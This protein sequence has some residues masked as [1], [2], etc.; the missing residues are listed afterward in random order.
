MECNENQPASTDLAVA[1]AKI[2][3]L[4]KQVNEL[5]EVSAQVASLKTDIHG[6]LSVQLELGRRM[7]LLEERQ[8]HRHDMLFNGIKRIAADVQHLKQ[9]VYSH[10]AGG[11]SDVDSGPGSARK[12]PLRSESLEVKSPGTVSAAKRASENRRNFER[13][14]QH[15]VTEMN[16]AKTMDELQS[17]GALAVKYSDQLFRN[18][19]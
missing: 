3:L 19:L 2:K 1:K 18:Y 11:D 9:H 8:L 15:H 4:Q 5:K 17:A 12:T 16:D 14:L 6:L 13:A 10:D 7:A